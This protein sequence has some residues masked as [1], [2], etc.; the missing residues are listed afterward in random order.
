MK[1]YDHIIRFALL[2]IVVIVGFFIV[3]SYKVPESFGNHGS[4]TY[5]YYRAD[6]K[7]EQAAHTVVYQGTEHCSSCHAPQAADLAEGT[8]AALDC[9]SCHGSFK[10]HNNNTTDRMAISDPIDT[11]MLCH[12]ALNA[13]PAEFP[14][15]DSFAAH[16]SEQDETLQPDMSCADCHDPHVPM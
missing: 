12:E 5:A 6:S 15:I 14:Q 16:L 4:Y 3:R 10:A 2:I 7:I 9:E 8:H 13:R 11:C 1:T